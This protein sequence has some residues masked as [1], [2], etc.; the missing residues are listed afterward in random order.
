MKFIWALRFSVIVFTIIQ[1]WRFKTIHKL[2]M[3]NKNSLFILLSL[4]YAI[5]CLS[6]SSS[7]FYYFFVFFFLLD[8]T[9]LEL[10]KKLLDATAKYANSHSNSNNSNCQINTCDSCIVGSHAVMCKYHWRWRD[11]Q[12]IK[13]S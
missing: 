11:C 5:T 4:P 2:C 6:L 10:E 12:N 8:S 9:I 1:L 13:H 3:S 7:F